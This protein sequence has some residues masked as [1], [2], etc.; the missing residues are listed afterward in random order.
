MTSLIQG[1][2]A[3]AFLVLTGNFSFSTLP[4]VFWIC[5]AAGLLKSWPFSFGKIARGGSMGTQILSFEGP[6]NI[7][8]KL[9]GTFVEQTPQW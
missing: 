1:V 7:E 4:M 5:L 2:V 9:K 3:M 6:R 8:R